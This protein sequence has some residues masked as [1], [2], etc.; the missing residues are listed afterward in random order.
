MTVWCVL[1]PQN[2]WYKC[3][4]AYKQPFTY[5]PVEEKKNNMKYLHYYTKMGSLTKKQQ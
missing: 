1:E 5:P 2:V 3:L 4:V